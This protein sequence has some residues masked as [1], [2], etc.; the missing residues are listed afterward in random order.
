MRLVS[1]D[2]GTPDGAAGVMLPTGEYLSVT[3]FARAG[4]LEAWAP[5]SW[6]RLLDA[7]RE[8]LE[9]V[10]AMHERALRLSDAEREALRAR[11]GLLAQDT[12][13]LAPIAN[14]S[15]ILAVGL[16]YKSHL[17][18]MSGTP[19]P[20]H[21]SAFMKSPA[22]ISG[23]GA[24]VSLPRQAA[25]HVDFEGELACVFARTCHNVSAADALDYVLG[26]TVAN[27]LSARDW[28]EAVWQAQ[29]P[30]EARL[31]WEVNIMGKQFPGFTVLGPAI[32][33]VDEVRN[34]ESQRL[35]TRLNGKIMQDALLSDMIFPLT[36]VIAHFS[37]WHTF[38]AGDILLTG[39]PA[40]VGVSRDPKVFLKDGD[41]VEVEITG[42]GRLVTQI[43]HA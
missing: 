43:S 16:A 24:C 14:P 17:A 12:A 42:L 35:T 27:D 25:R 8:G 15:L 6:R 33:T 19:A 2:D 28:V 3:H 36:E 20:K 18:E 26:F 34:L 7:G 13:L 1:L 5:R 39:T 22:S 32:V 38:R 31:T 4:T 30:W 11:G 29:A 41:C 10:G 21:P 23:P 9:L 37:R 40:G